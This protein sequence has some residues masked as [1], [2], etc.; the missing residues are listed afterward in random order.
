MGFI[1]IDEN[2]S[3][4]EELLE[5]INFNNEIAVRLGQEITKLK[6]TSV[7]KRP[8]RIP[9]SNKVATSQPPVLEEPIQEML[10]DEM[11]YYIENVREKKGQEIVNAFPSTENNHY[12]KIMLRLKLETI[13]A[14]REIKK[15]M[16]L[17]KN[18]SKEELIYYK[19]ELELEIRKLNIINDTLVAKKNASIE[20]EVK[21]KKQ[22]KND[23]LLVPTMFGNC[24]VLEE[25]D[26]IPRDY[27]EG[28]KELFLSI[29]NGTFKN[30]KRFNASNDGLAGFCEVKDFKIRVVYDRISS[31]TYSIITVF[32]KK[33]DNDKS[34]LAP[35]K[36]KIAEYKKIRPI[37]E[38]KLSDDSFRKE[39]DFNVAELWNKLG[40]K[41]KKVK[42]AIKEKGRKEYD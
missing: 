27:Y 23:L 30:I 36:R 11:L 29:E 41:N 38:K 15:L 21:E 32:M 14:I 17:T 1:I 31:T 6:H 19:D 33:S 37:L 35:L 7:L 3:T 2:K 5:A 8:V 13:R 24:R 18:I 9:N 22:I 39:N 42:G 4:K 40:R 12:F 25:L 34:Y 28:I 16:T 26:K 10:E 20:T